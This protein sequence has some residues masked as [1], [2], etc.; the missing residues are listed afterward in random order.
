[1]N[2]LNQVRVATIFEG[3]PHAI[4]HVFKCKRFRFGLEKLKFVYSQKTKGEDSQTS[5][6]IW[7]FGC[8]VVLGLSLL[9]L[10]IIIIIIFLVLVVFYLFVCLF[11]LAGKT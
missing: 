2:L 10:F 9:Y 1:M 11:V 5:S 3:Y 4:R 7:H 6:L 8:A